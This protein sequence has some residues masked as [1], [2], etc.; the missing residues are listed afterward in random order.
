MAR[1]TTSLRE[2]ESDAPPL[3]QNIEAEQALLGAILINNGAYEKVAET[4]HVE[5]FFLP[6]HQRLY[7]AIGELIQSGTLADPVTLRNRFQADAALIGAGGAA[8]LARLIEGA[9][10]ILNAPHYAAAILDCHRRRVLAQ[11]GRDM[12][13]RAY[14]GKEPIDKQV[15][16][17][18]A[19]LLTVGETSAGSR[20]RSG[21]EAA[22]AALDAAQSAYRNP[23]GLAGISSG[24][25]ALDALVGGFA[26]GDLYIVGARPGL[27]KTALCGSIMW[28]ALMGGVGVH[29]FSGEMTATQLMARLMGAMTGISASRQRRGDLAAADWESLIEAQRTIAGWKLVVDD[30]AMAL[31]RITQQLNHARRKAGVTLA[32]VDYLQLAVSGADSE[33]RLVDVGRVSKGLKRLAKDLDIPIIAS[34]QLSRAVES[35]DDKRPTLADLRQTGEI[36]QDADVVILIY[37]EEYYL[38]RAEPRQNPNEPPLKFQERHALWSNVLAS[39]RGKAEL[40]VAKH[41]HDRDGVARVR[42]DGARTFFHDF[43]DTQGGFF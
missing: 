40:I 41:R 8:Y 32:F 35:R 30:G 36:E 14:N 20:V 2:P 31:P 34:A 18:S 1:R 16:D 23:G 21:A 27:G 43:E 13:N 17:A 42:F 38:S 9:V 7:E 4:L 24:I 28:A 10:S 22:Q 11:L 12:V 26:P 39:S 15:E 29:F 3:P 19:A 5:H 33:S 25:K 6:V 37:R